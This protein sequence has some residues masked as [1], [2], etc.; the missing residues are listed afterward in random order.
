[1]RAKYYNKSR[2]CPLLMTLLTIRQKLPSS[3]N[4]KIQTKRVIISYLFNIIECISLENHAILAVQNSES[5][6]SKFL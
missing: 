5:N 2:D 4:F 1:M 3:K 6:V